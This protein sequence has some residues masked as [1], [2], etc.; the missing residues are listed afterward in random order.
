M[1]LQALHL[2]ILCDHLVYY[3]LFKPHFVTADLKGQNQ[4]F[5]L[6][7]MN[8]QLNRV[9]LMFLPPKVIL[10]SRGLSVKIYG[11]VGRNTLR[12]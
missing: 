10:G 11:R 9:T 4:F 8:T 5:S 2:L 3:N 12:N 7:Y 1:I 6:L